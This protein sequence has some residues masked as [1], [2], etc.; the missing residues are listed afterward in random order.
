MSKET[1]TSEGEVLE[2]LPNNEFKVLFAEG[3]EIRCYTSGKMRINKIKVVV[4]DKVD[5]VLD[6]YG[7]IGRIVK[8]K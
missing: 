6:D 3:K 5:V 2:A 7:H 8:R 4:G 1:K